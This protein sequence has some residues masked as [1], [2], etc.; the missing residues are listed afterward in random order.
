MFQGERPNAVVRK[1]SHWLFSESLSC[2]RTGANGRASSSQSL[3]ALSK[4]SERERRHHQERLS[5]VLHTDEPPQPSPSSAAASA[6]VAVLPAATLSCTTY[7]TVSSRAGARRPPPPPQEIFL[8]GL[9]HGLAFLPCWTL[10]SPP[11]PPP[12]S[13]LHG[14]G[15]A[16]RPGSC[17]S[18]PVPA[19]SRRAP[20]LCGRGWGGQ[21]TSADPSSS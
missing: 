3:G 7:W 1:P 19:T 21:R 11:L 8:A 17:L 16:V 4:S 10:L 13:N 12:P 2:A 9:L 18:R 15:A 14:H 20:V 6:T 5:Y